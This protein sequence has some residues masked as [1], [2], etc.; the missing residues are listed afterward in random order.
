MKTDRT[1][2]LL[3]GVFMF[4][5]AGTALA[6]KK[7]MMMDKSQ[8]RTQEK[9]REMTLEQEEKGAEEAAGELERASMGEGGERVR[10]RIMSRF[11]VDEDRIKSMREEGGMSYGEISLALGLAKGMEG[12]INDENIARITELR[13]GKPKTGW[14][15]IA[16]DLGQKLGPAVGEAKKM[17]AELRKEAKER[18]GKDGKKRKEMKKDM[19]MKHD[20]NMKGHGEDMRP[21]GG[22]GGGKGG[23]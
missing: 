4:A 21:M 19:K 8:E 6:Q 10:S 20:R 1:G 7:E 22:G 3:A 14:G 16:K 11:G 9:K 5:A 13:Q 23:R 15:K 12:G 18:K 2:L 17:A